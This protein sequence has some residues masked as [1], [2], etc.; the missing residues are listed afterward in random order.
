MYIHTLLTLLYLIITYT[1]I[2][3]VV[4]YRKRLLYRIVMFCAPLF[5]ILI[6]QVLPFAI[7]VYPLQYL[8]M[9]IILH[10]SLRLMFDLNRVSAFW[11]AMSFIFSLLI[12]RGISMG[13]ITTYLY[14]YPNSD[15]RGS[16]YDI[17]LLIA[18]ILL[19]IQGVY[20]SRECNKQNLH[21]LFSVNS[22]FRL[23]CEVKTVL[24]I[25]LMLITA[26]YFN[27][28]HGYLIAIFRIS[29]CI[30]AAI[31][32]QVVLNMTVKTADWMSKESDY[33]TMKQNWDVQLRQYERQN[34]LINDSRHYDHDMKHT[35]KTIALLIEEGNVELAKN[36]LNDI[37]RHIGKREEDARQFSN[38][39]LLDTLLFNYEA[40]CRSK[41]IQYRAE[42]YFPNDD[43]MND[44]DLCRVFNNIFNNAYEA[45]LKVENEQRRFISIVSRMQAHWLVIAIKNRYDGELISSHNVLLTTKKDFEHHGMGIKNVQGIIRKYSGMC[46]I[47]SDVSENIFTFMIFIPIR[48]DVMINDPI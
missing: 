27:S 9:L 46:E 45:C 48:D 25:Y 37:E 11:I 15:L 21:T 14:L 36:M 33:I 22:Q 10:I 2:Y 38:H 31:T 1:I 34:E 40:I 3:F 23:I 8:I 47:N 24:L 44:V 39:A 7:E 30:F 16:T 13:C 20:Y 17:S 4:P 28:D 19:V 26:F 18:S 42:C 32:Y 12:V 5:I 41:H 43:V 35:I 29:S 6:I